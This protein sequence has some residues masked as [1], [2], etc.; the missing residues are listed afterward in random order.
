MNN[1]TQS[2]ASKLQFAAG[3][4]A[5]LLLSAC[6]STGHPVS[7]LPYET[8]G[9]PTTRETVCR[10]WGNADDASYCAPVAARTELSSRN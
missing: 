7:A 5:A 3:L 2:G 6:A 9:Q 10:I 4:A 8:A 1:S